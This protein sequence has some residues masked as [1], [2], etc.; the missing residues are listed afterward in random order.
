MAWEKFGERFAESYNKYLED[1]ADRKKAKKLAKASL[2]R[3]IAS[4]DRAAVRVAEAKLAST[5][6]SLEGRAEGPLGDALAERR[7]STVPS[8]EE[9]PSMRIEGPDVEGEAYRMLTPMEAVR[10]RMPQG[11]PG[12]I[13]NVRAQQSYLSGI[14]GARGRAAAEP[15]A[16]KAASLKHRAQIAA[17]EESEERTAALKARAFA[18]EFEQQSA[19][20]R[21]ENRFIAEKGGKVRRTGQAGRSGEQWADV[22]A[23]IALSE[24][25]AKV[26]GEMYNE[27]AIGAKDYL[28][29]SRAGRFKRTIAN[30]I[31]DVNA[32]FTVTNPW[33]ITDP[34]HEIFEDLIE[35]ARKGDDA[36]IRNAVEQAQADALKLETDMEGRMAAAEKLPE[37][38]A[39]QQEF[40]KWWRGVVSR[41][42]TAGRAGPTAAQITAE[43]VSRGIDPLAVTTHAAGR[44]GQARFRDFNYRNLL[45]LDQGWF[46]GAELAETKQGGKPVG[47][48]TAFTALGTTERMGDLGVAEKLKKDTATALRLYKTHKG[49][50]SSVAA[51]APT[52]EVFRLVEDM[53]NRGSATAISSFK[54]AEEAAGM[55]FEKALEHLSLPAGTP[56]LTEP[57]PSGESQKIVI[58]SATGPTVV[59]IFYGTRFHPNLGRKLTP[60]EIKAAKD[61]RKQRSGFSRNNA[62]STKMGFDVWDIVK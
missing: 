50:L 55:D 3:A 53:V 15:A 58:N 47:Y 12:T 20:R 24:D 39:A 42:P 18:R 17:Q 57:M 48:N 14:E 37:F 28:S 19:A 41:I 11:E 2:K 30:G 4:E 5:L 22:R 8:E 6:E 61:E 62:L 33:Q 23:G 45:K 43:A 56:F 27:W 25:E 16:M 29:L 31:A 60:A 7:I 34:E 51:A 59:E 10:S 49:N 40:D 54:K 36:D 32:G 9:L 44:I 26:G 1:E 52:P 38:Y 35:V 46:T 13:G 21:K